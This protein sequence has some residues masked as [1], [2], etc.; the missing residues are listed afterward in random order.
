[1]PT[2][3]P[4]QRERSSSPNECTS[5]DATRM[6]PKD[7]E[8]IPVSRLIRVVLPLPDL[9]ITATNSPSA[10]SRLTSCNATVAPAMDSYVFATLEREISGCSVIV[11][12]L[13]EG[14][15]GSD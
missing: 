9:P 1:M 10:I 4:L 15:G 11:E 13:H 2:H 12:T 5:V 3:L 6:V 14:S 7:G 8:S